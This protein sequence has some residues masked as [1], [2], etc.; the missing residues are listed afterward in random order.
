MKDRYGWKAVWRAVGG[1]VVD[2]FTVEAANRDEAHALAL[3]RC[4][5][6]DKGTTF[7]PYRIDVGR[8]VPMDTGL[9]EEV[10]TNAVA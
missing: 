7:R 5:W 1:R 10:V 3:E 4:S 6:T 2:T 8:R 9:E